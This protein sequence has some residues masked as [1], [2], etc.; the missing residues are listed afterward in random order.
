MKRATVRDL[1]KAYKE[2]KYFQVYDRTLQALDQAVSSP[3][4]FYQFD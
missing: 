4:L 2:A 1:L 3:Y